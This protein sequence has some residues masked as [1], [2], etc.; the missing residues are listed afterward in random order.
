[1]GQARL[2]APGWTGCCSARSWACS[3]SAP[4]WSG[5][6]PSTATTSP[7]ATRAPTS[8]KQV[9]NIAIGLV[10]AG[11]RS[12]ATDHRWVRILTPLVYVASV[13][14][15][16][17]VLVDGQPRSTAP[18][19]GSR[20]GGLSVQPSEFAKLA[21][22][23]GM[24]LVVAERTEGRLRGARSASSTWSA[25]L[26][27]AGLPAVLI[28]LQPDLGTMLVLS[29]TVFGVL[30]V[31]G[32]A[33]PLAGPAGRRGRHGGGRRGVGR[34]AQAPT[35]STAS[36]PSPTPASTRAAPATTP[37]RPGSRSATAGSSGRA[38]STGPRPESGFVPE[39]HTDFIFTV[40]GEELGLVGAGL[41][42]ALL[43][44]VIWRA[45]SIAAACRG[46]VRPGG[47]S[48][49]RVL[50]RAS[51]PSRTSACAWASCR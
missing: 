41:L 34:G 31:A 21:V 30:A 26:A 4:C 44:V 43:A 23:I 45:L 24:A 9:V 38:C 16:V 8:R 39:Q 47:R 46:H 5:R 40:A 3:C 50:V 27:I 25:M 32:S 51:R 17:L 33:P 19:P 1:M 36:W 48:G 6:P 35:R 12:M 10:L 13:A 7:G 37:N 2:R 42:I 14:G 11:C 49:H 18:G 29:A 28:L 15:L 22:V 20:L